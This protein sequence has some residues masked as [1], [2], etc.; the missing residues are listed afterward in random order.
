MD[1]SKSTLTSSGFDPHSLRSVSPQATMNI[2]TSSPVGKILYVV[3]SVDISVFNFI[4]IQYI[5]CLNAFIF[6][7]FM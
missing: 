1:L 3:A 7:F 2:Q 6:I 5:Y 4:F